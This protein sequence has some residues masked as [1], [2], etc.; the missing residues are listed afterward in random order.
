M[1]GISKK[2]FI[3]DYSKKMMDGNAALF[4]GA[5]LSCPAGFVEWNELLKEI[6]EDLGLKIEREYDLI[7]L[8][9]YHLNER[10]SR[11]KLNEK[12]IEEFTKNAKPTENHS[13]IARLPIHT[14]WTTNYDTLIEDAIR[15]EYKH[16]DVKI[17]SNN[18]AQPHPGTDV[19]IFKM[20]GDISQ[21]NEAVLTKDD[22]EKYPINRE[23][24][25][26]RLKGD[27]TSHT[28]LFIGFSFSDP[29]I[30]YILSRIKNL[31]GQNT[32]VHYCI[33]IK[34]K[35]KPKPSPIEKAD[36]EYE[37]RKLELRVGDLKRFGIQTVLVDSA[38]EI[39][40]LL[41][42]LHKRAFYNNI[43]VSGSSESDAPSFPL[44]RLMS[45]SNLLGKE[46]IRRG[47]NLVSGY[48]IGIG[49]E[50]IVGALE[51]AYLTPSNIH[52]RLIL[53]PFPYTIESSEKKRVYQRWRK[54][55][56]SLA[57]FSIFLA[58]NKLSMD[59]NADVIFSD[60]VWDEF[61]I[62]T[63]TSIHTCPI[64]IGAT[65][66]VAAQIWKKV[67]GDTV[68]FF[69]HIDVLDELEILNNPNQPDDKLIEAVFNIIDKV[70]SEQ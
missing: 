11:T 16:V 25:T 43:F 18:I 4:I 58:G 23:L 8:A 61:E 66:F 44:S 19:T 62:A 69:G 33:I 13:L 55:M 24:F 7:A 54:A 3:R 15:E 51:D 45:F 63:S 2:Q 22:Y 42:E 36:S 5:G 64:P 39:T 17:T 56:V 21:P 30:D 68:N 35:Q 53:R 60:G 50:L 40:G 10:S 47:Y 6:A 38:D 12:L 59:N 26:I 20:H 67:S 29:N 32:P 28:F 46:I 9:Q 27:L 37:L 52:E 14:I 31:L 65:G 48:G 57:G 49:S 1:I 34:P 70:R 41:Q